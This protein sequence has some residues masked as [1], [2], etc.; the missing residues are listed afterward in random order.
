M[1]ACTCR[2]GVD[3]NTPSDRRNKA[4]PMMASDG[5]IDR[6]ECAPYV[7]PSIDQAPNLCRKDTREAQAYTCLQCIA[8]GCIGSLLPIE[9]FLSNLEKQSPPKSD[10]ERKRRS[11]G[12]AARRPMP[13]THHRKCLRP[14]INVHRLFFYRTVHRYIY[15]LVVMS[16]G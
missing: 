15:P 13:P 10:P 2:F 9:R 3:E 6:K 12:R 16:G 7:Y 1:L 4:R 8:S 11:C 14:W 5:L